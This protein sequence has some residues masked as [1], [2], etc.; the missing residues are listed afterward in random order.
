[1]QHIDPMSTVLYKAQLN[2]AMVISIIQS[3]SFLLSDLR[4]LPYILLAT[5]LAVLLIKLL[6]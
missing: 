4:H 3:Q 5:L 6:I 1:M 2:Q